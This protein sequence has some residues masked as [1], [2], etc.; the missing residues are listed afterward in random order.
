MSHPPVI[1]TYE[2]REIVGIA[3]IVPQ[4]PFERELLE[5][6]GEPCVNDL[7]ISHFIPYN[8]FFTLVN[9]KCLYMSRSDR[10]DK[11]FEDSSLTDENIHH[12][13]PMDQVI[14]GH[15]GPTVFDGEAA[16]ADQLGHRQRVCLHCWRLDWERNHRMWMIYGGS[17]RGVMI[18]STSHRLWRSVSPRTGMEKKL[19]RVVYFPPG[20]SIP[21][22]FPGLAFWAKRECFYEDKEVRLALTVSEHLFDP[23]AEAQNVVIDLRELCVG[24]VCGPSLS[25]D[26]VAQVKQAV[27]SFSTIKVELE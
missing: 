4:T 1:G 13:A 3:P 11:D 15:F 22:F 7:P 19:G 18:Q 27:H 17:G 21:T 24:I 8:H 25:E 9:S 6:I 16:H 26:E 10:Q 20:T 23:S 14:H 5:R 2:N 12:P